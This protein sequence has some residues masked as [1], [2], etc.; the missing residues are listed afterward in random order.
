MKAQTQLAKVLESSRQAEV[1]ALAAVNHYGKRVLADT[2]FWL[3]KLQ[4]DVIPMLTMSPSWGASAEID[5][6][7]LLKQ[8]VQQIK[9]KCAKGATMCKTVL[10]RKQIAQGIY[11]SRNFPIVIDEYMENVAARHNGISLSITVE[12]DA[13]QAVIDVDLLDIIIDNA[14]H[15]AQIHGKTGKP[16]ELRVYV[17]S[18]RFMI[19]ITNRAGKDHA[20]CF[21]LQRHGRIDGAQAA[22]VPGIGGADSTF[23]GLDEIY[24][25]ALMM[26]HDTM[27][28][29]TFEEDSVLFTL[30]L[31]LESVKVHKTSPLPP[32]TVLICLDDDFSVR[33]Q[34]SGLR[35]ALRLPMENF[36]ILG[37]TYDEASSVYN[38]ALEACKSHA[39]VV[40]V[41]DQNLN[42]PEGDLLGTDIASRLTV[43][44]AFTGLIFMRSAND[45]ITDVLF[46]RSHGA[47]DAIPKSYGIKTL[48]ASLLTRVAAEIGVPAAMSSKSSA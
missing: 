10:L 16:V 25:V 33:A 48:A 45:S 39:L 8:V 4:A 38:A 2:V 12:K 46:Y 1:S 17:E 35:K 14:L 43:T 18:G 30:S 47:I 20:A 27:A 42:Y 7:D 11:E 5:P 24:E 36:K 3:K 6:M 32:D 9:E 22:A 37:A 31:P 34:Y 15:N 13:Q 29:L 26:P 21:E 44:D 28:R 40:C 23:R 19:C 41:L